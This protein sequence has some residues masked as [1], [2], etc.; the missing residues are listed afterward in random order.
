M[1]GGALDLITKCMSVRANAYSLGG[2]GVFAEC[3]EVF[4]SESVTEFD[5]SIRVHLKN[6]GE[7]LE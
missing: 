5:S 2:P 1:R 4:L 6:G 7:E 3:C